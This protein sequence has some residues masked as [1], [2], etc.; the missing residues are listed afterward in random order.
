MYRTFH[1]TFDRQRTFI[2]KIGN[3]IVYT[4]H[5]MDNEDQSVK[6]L[7]YKTFPDIWTSDL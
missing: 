6:T 3:L 4:M 2:S 7:T 5:A 1:N